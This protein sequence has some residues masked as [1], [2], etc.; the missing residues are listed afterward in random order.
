[1]VGIPDFRSTENANS[2]KAYSLRRSSLLT[3]LVK[4]VEIMH[5]S[6][7]Q[8]AGEADRNELSSSSNDDNHSQEVTVVMA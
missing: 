4:R 1:M 5:K 6:Y 3:S 7:E 2:Q 8:I